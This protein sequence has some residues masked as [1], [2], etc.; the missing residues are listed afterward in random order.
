MLTSYRFQSDFQ[1]KLNVKI[2]DFNEH[3]R[4]LKVLKPLFLVSN[5][6]IMSSGTLFGQAKN[7]SFLV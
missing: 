5:R 7:Y 2:F 4:F 3:V 6:K 1:T